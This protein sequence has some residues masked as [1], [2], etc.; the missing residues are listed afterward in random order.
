MKRD[1]RLRQLSDDHHQ[2]LVLARR[3]T[4]AA[5][6]EPEAS[7]VVWNEVVRRFHSELAPHFSVEEQHILPA[8]ERA[9][10]GALAKRTRDEHAALRRIVSD[11]QHDIATRLDRFGALLRDHVRFEERVL[12]EAVQERLDGAALDAVNEACRARTS[13]P[14]PRD[15]SA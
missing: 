10:G 4:S 3:A 5:S 12:F 15:R 11:D 2:A 14:H 7:V 6:A 1:R 13:A 9:G 8:L